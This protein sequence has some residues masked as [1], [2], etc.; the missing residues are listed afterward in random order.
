MQERDILSTGHQCGYM[1]CYSMHPTLEY[2]FKKFMASMPGVESIDEL[3][4]TSAFPGKPRADYIFGA[5][6]IIVELKTLKVD[7]SQKVGK[8]LDKH[9]NREDF[10][11]FYGK[12]ELNKI[13]NHLPDGRNVNRKIYRNVTRSIEDAFRSAENQIEGTEN[14][15]ELKGNVGLL[16]ILNEMIEVFSP[17]IVASRVSELLCA[18]ENRTNPFS[19]IDYVWL[20]FES[21]SINVPGKPPGHPSTL[22]E[23]PMAHEFEWF[24]AHFD[25]LEAEWARSCG[26]PLYVWKDAP[27]KLADVR[28]QFLNPQRNKG[29]MKRHDFFERQYEAMPYLR[30]LTDTQVRDHGAKV[31]NGLR[32]YS[33]RAFE[34]TDSSDPTLKALELAWIHFMEEARHRGLDLSYLRKLQHVAGKD[35]T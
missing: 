26:S 25:L 34:N 33:Q 31:F 30:H 22:L 10:P 23:G 14:I 7:P 12:V 20:L 1:S 9:R 6:Q 21:H 16:V 32:P 35:L 24:R 4:P 2:R 17:D 15:L 3:I 8:E 13:L 28:F 11:L 29:E 27:K 19:S 5:R 18:R